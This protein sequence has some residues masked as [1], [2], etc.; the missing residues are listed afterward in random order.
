MTLYVKGEIECCL[1]RKPALVEAQLADGQFGA[2]LSVP[3]LPDGW[4]YWFT[5]VICA[6]PACVAKRDGKDR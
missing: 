2:R 6:D 3:R 4:S 1:C 5:S